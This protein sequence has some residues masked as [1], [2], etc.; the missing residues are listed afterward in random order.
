MADEIYKSVFENVYD[1]AIVL[2]HDGYPATVEAVKRLL[3][4]LNAAGYQ[5]L[6]VSAASKINNR[7]LRKG[8][9]YIRV[10][11]PNDTAQ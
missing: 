11:K 9:V 6:S 7:P 5:T 2:M 8:S 3:P 4:D 1:G 10:R